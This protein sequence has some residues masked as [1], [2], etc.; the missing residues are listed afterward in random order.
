M[1]HGL[2]S[3]NDENFLEEVEI[4]NSDRDI[5]NSV[6]N[7]SQ[8]NRNTLLKTMVKV[9]ADNHH[10]DI[11]SIPSSLLSLTYLQKGSK[12]IFF[13]EEEK[14]MALRSED[15]HM[16]P[17]FSESCQSINLMK[18]KP[19]RGRSSDG[20]NTPINMNSFLLT[21]Y[22]EESKTEHPCCNKILIVDDN[23]FNVQSL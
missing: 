17:L 16:K 14:L 10:S 5:G 3:E 18:E 7:R 15:F 6:L 1:Q 12:S 21:E 11:Q 22:D 13:S 2:Q 23:P 9:P 8:Q 20:Y 4:D 19:G